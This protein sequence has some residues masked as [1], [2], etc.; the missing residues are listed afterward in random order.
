LFAFR[1]CLNIFVVVIPRI[2][3]RIILFGEIGASSILLF[4]ARALNAG[5]SIVSPIPSWYPVGNFFSLDFL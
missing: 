5:S 4:T 2:R 3:L 1:W